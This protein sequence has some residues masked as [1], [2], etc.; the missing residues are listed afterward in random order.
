MSLLLYTLA[1]ARILYTT[2]NSQLV[3]CEQWMAK[4]GEVATKFQAFSV[5]RHLF[6][7]ASSRLGGRH[8]DRGLHAYMKGKYPTAK[9]EPKE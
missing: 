1:Y 5:L 9:H 7:D 2:E 3:P 4:D 6:S 8:C